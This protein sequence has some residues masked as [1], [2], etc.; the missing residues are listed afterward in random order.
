MTLRKVG[1][2]RWGAMALTAAAMAASAA[3]AAVLL[4]AASPPAAA[5]TPAGAASGPGAAPAL[6]SVSAAPAGAGA[7]AAHDGVVE[8]VRQTV[9]AAQVSGAVVQLDVKVGDRVRAGQVLLRLDA[10]AADQGAVASEAQVR[11]ALAAQEVAEKEVVRQRQLAAD[12]FIS[13]AALE[14]AEAEYKAASAQAAAL[15]A[16]AGAAR[17]QTG[18]YVVRAPYAGVVS[19]VPVALGDMAMPGRA[20]FTLYDPA[21]LRVAAAV[22]QSAVAA[23]GDSKAVRVELPGLPA[24]QG[25]AAPRLHMP[26]RV[27]PLP[28]ADAGTHTVTL[29]ADL[30]PGLQGAEGL[31]PG[32]FARLWLPA[33]AAAATGVAPSPWVP[34]QAVVRRAEMTGLYVLDGNGKPLLRQVR[35]GR[36]DGK[37]VEVL[38]GLNAGERVATDAQAA[39]RSTVAQK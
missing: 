38:A 30:A 21:A 39:A 31:R 7:P 15:L 8:A 37:Q 4:W 16:Q 11:A 20:L 32:Q 12:R 26:L 29:R 1:G 34:V 36:S 9:V 19:E 23:L 6:A 14:R 28:A 18:F 24:A 33:A 2:A 13:T 17:T 22:P 10:R 25:A 3:A 5:G 35:L 27:Q